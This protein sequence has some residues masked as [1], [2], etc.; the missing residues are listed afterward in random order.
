MGNVGYLST[1][2]ALAA[3]AA[4]CVA[5]FS[6]S[7]PMRAAATALFALFAAGL[8]VNRNLTALLAAG[9]GFS[10]LFILRLGK[11]AWVPIAGS[12]AVLLLVVVAYRP[13]RGRIAS[14]A[15]AAR[16][17]DWD[18]LVT[19]R[20]GAWAA[21][22]EMARERPLLGFGPGTFGAE[23]V[24]H[25]LAAEM[26]L[27]RRFINPQGTSSYGEAHCDYLQP[28]A[29]AGIPGGLAALGAAA[30]VFTGALRRARRA[31][32]EER[33]ETALLLALLAAG[34][35]A[36]LTW[37]PLQ[38]P[39]TAVPLLLAAG[40]AWRKTSL[41]F[42][43]ESLELKSEP[44]NPKPQTLNSKPAAL[45]AR[46]AFVAVL[47]ALA[48]PELPRYGA[49]RKLRAA[50][51][52]FRFVLTRHTEISD[53]PAALGRVADIALDAAGALPGDARPW[54]LAGGARLAVG[55][56][57][58]AI[59]L[60][61]LA[62]AQGER[63][64]IDLDLGRACD[65][66]ARRA[67]ADAWFTRGGWVSPVLL[68]TLLPDVAGPVRAKIASLEAELKAGRLAAPSPLPLPLPL[69]E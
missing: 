28:L 63:A 57:E 30:L 11:R 50:Q 47:T 1:A 43:V 8:A 61:R 16:A 21:A 25:R 64:E 32:Q 31:P 22:L 26:R 39:I 33:G 42:R 5:L 10:L 60:Y 12:L 65:A 66:L 58:R 69:P 45:F 51:A 23:F 7:W 35:A 59:G 27:R 36:A 38:R 4:L 40:R 37:F 34:A 68:G 52:A 6:R 67:E 46:I 19:Y 20:G 2:L 48:W 3:V 9:A 29:E 24:P 49:E 18:N 62:L 13:L 54:V 44:P 53:P 41:E 17:G 55:E 15:A 56:G 14:T